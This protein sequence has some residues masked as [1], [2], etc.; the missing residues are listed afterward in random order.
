MSTAFH[1]QFTLKDFGKKGKGLLCLEYVQPNKTIFEFTGNVFDTLPVE[2]SS[3]FQI[4]KNR[5][6]GPSGDL[7]DYVNHSCNPNCWIDILGNRIFLKSLYVLTPNT[8]VTIDYSLLFTKEYQYCDFSCVC[9]T[10]P[11]RKRIGGWD[12]LT[13]PQQKHYL[14]LDIIPGYQ[15]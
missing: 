6:L 11:C 7:D 14:D 4:S 9:G 1:N 8:E 2:K 3:Y 10:L 5:F 15:K 13:S 12:S